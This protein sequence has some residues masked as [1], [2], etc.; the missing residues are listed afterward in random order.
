[1]SALR[2]SWSLVRG[3]WCYV[4]GVKFFVGTFAFFVSWLWH[5]YVAPSHFTPFGY[6]IGMIPSALMAPFF[7]ILVT[8]IYISLRVEKEGLDAQALSNNLGL[9]DKLDED[10]NITRHEQSDEEEAAMEL[11][12]LPEVA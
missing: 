6:I 4:F 7:S 8:I 2:R 11:S 1:M 3:K 10:V 12:G 5:V 9:V